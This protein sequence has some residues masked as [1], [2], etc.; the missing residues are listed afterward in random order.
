MKKMEQMLI[1]CIISLIC[2]SSPVSAQS[3]MNF[4]G[5]LCFTQ[6]ALL[7]VADA[8]WKRGTSIQYDENRR[9]TLFL[10]EEAMPDQVRYLSCVAFV[11]R[12]YSVAANISLPT[13]T[14]EYAAAVEHTKYEVKGLTYSDVQDWQAY[15]EKIKEEAAASE[16]EESAY[17]LIA[18]DYAEMLKPCDIISYKVGSSGHVVMVY[19][20]I[21]DETGKAVDAWVIHASG[22]NDTFENQKSKYNK[23]FTEGGIQKTKLSSLLCQIFDLRLSRLHVLRCW[24]RS[25]VTFDKLADRRTSKTVVTDYARACIN[26][27]NIRRDFTSKKGGKA[28]LSKGE[29]DTYTV[30]LINDGTSAKKNIPVQITVPYGMETF[31]AKN[32]KITK[33]GSGV[34][35]KE[36]IKWSVTVPAGKKV[37]VSAV[38]K[39]TRVS[40]LRAATGVSAAVGSFTFGM[41]AHSLYHS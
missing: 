9:S 5:A 40:D 10:P 8:Y 28:V 32:G 3:G 6:K 41:I 23:K 4:T 16:S 1:A 30:T 22:S 34:R 18:E 39:V 27:N 35:K 21:Y 2:F 26:W 36:V 38:L 15:K 13:S 7:A 12:V 25:S 11:E 17:S 24:N 31:S 29:T 33:T 14:A 37:T 19:D 20:L